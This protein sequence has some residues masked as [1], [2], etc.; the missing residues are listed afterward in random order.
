MKLLFCPHCQDVLKL[1]RKR[2]D[3]D[4]GASWGYYEDDLVAKIGGDAIPL[5]FGNR[6]FIDALEGRPTDGRGSQFQAFVIPT[7]APSVMDEGGG[8]K[9]KFRGS[10]A[11]LD[12]LMDACLGK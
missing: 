3:C 12:E 10:Q 8:S 6:S 5:G 9:L 2:R 11:R 1:L 7:S 4:C